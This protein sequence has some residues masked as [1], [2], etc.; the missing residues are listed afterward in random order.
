MP[1]R[2]GAIGITYPGSKKFYAPLYLNQILKIVPSIPAFYD[3]MAGG[4]GITA[5]AMKRHEVGEV[6]YND[7]DKDIYELVKFAVKEKDLPS[8]WYEWL[9]REDFEDLKNAI[10][11]P[12][13]TALLLSYSFGSNRKSYAFNAKLEGYKML[14]HK[15][16]TNTASDYELDEFRSLVGAE[17]PDLG[18]GS[19]NDRRMNFRHFV[20][21]NKA[22]LQKLNASVAW[23]ANLQQLQQLEQLEQLEQVKRMQQLERLHLFNEDYRYFNPREGVVFVDPPYRHTATNGYSERVNYNEL[24]QWFGNLKVPAFMCEYEAPFECIW[25]HETAQYASRGTHREGKPRRVEKLFWNGVK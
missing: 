3:V 5:E 6:V 22:T 13:R 7:A 14:A 8:D 17:L 2:K 15:F 10:S 1:Y 9:S 18:S 19:I 11:S 16:V 24:Y 23:P 4:A 21:A 20:L 25:K 12:K